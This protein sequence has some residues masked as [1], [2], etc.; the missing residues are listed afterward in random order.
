MVIV[1]MV[2]VVMM[3]TKMKIMLTG[4]SEGRRP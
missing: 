1:M 2:A 4:I 3:M